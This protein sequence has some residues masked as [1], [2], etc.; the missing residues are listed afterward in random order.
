MLSRAF[1]SLLTCAFCVSGSAQERMSLISVTNSWK[2]NFTGTNLSGQFQRPDYD[3][4]A[5][6]S[7][8]GVLG[9]DASIPYLY[10]ELRTQF[11]PGTGS[12]TTIYFRTH[13]NF[14][15]NTLGAELWSTNYVDDGAVFYLN[16]HE[17]Q[18]VRM[19]S[20]SI[21]YNTL[22]YTISNPEGQGNV[23]NFP[24]TNLIQG[25]NVL[26]VEVHQE[27][28][29]DPD[30]IFGMS[31][32]ALLPEP[33]PV[34]ITNQPPSRTIEES[35]STTFVA[36]VAGTPPYF[37]QW[38]K[39]GVE[40][41]GETNRSLTLNFVSLDAAG[42]YSFTVS[43]EFNSATSSNA[44]LAV[45][46]GPYLFV[47]MTDTWRYNA[48]GTN[49]GVNWRGVG[50]SDFLWP[51][52]GG[53]FYN[54]SGPLPAP[55]G[56]QLPL[57]NSSGQ[58]IITWYFRTRFHWSGPTS[59]VRLRART[60][61]DDGAVFYINGIEAGRLGMPAAPAIIGYNTPAAYRVEGLTDYNTIELASPA[62]VQGENVLAVE[63]HQNSS[64][65]PDVVFG[66]ALST[67]FAVSLPD[68]IFWGPTSAYT[69]AQSFFPE[70]CDLNEGCGTCSTRR[71]L[72]FD[73]ETRNIGQA[74]LVL[75]DP[76]NNP[77]FVQDPCHGHYHFEGFAEYR[78]LDTNG[79]QVAVGNKIGFCLLDYA[80]WDPNASS[81]DYYNC[82]Y[83]GIQ[84][85][86][87]DFY[88]S[89]LPCQW[90]D[91][92]GLPGGTYIL[93][94]E[95]DPQNRIVEAD[96]NNNVARVMVWFPDCAPPANDEF[97]AA[98][99]IPEAISSITFD[100]RCA[101]QECGEPRHDPGQQGSASIWYQWTAPGNGKLLLST[102]G[103]TFDTLVAVYRGPDLTNLTLVARDDDSGWYG[104]SRLMCDTV[105]GTRYSI[106][107][108][109]YYGRGSN[110]LFRLHY[111]PLVPPTFVSAELQATQQLRLTLSGEAADAYAIETYGTNAIWTE[112]LRVTNRTGT[113]QVID[114]AA[115]GPLKC[116]RARLLP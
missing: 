13:F 84:R 114:P 100:S 18:R 14:P 8:P 16:G 28:F 19:P 50:F 94:L 104:T 25:D 48:G 91:I 106:A 108:D 79:V 86:W 21:T 15:S 77:L 115:T 36:E 30:I 68:L 10:P 33:G 2:Y 51:E 49:L 57:T 5:W 102:E 55:K 96:E 99:V 3:D 73:T 41:F 111:R 92:T 4:A 101:T 44:T 95:V 58:G 63:V 98:Q 103:S 80:R 52:A 11:P 110:G 32:L 37:F 75:G 67:N 93:E 56:T 62:L 97:I 107:V 39:D 31:L 88:Y 78:L 65:T 69:E 9:Y 83:Q 61:I 74:D 54:Y 38:F 70:P 1:W 59:G 46:P 64:G 6:P 113:V 90:V 20:G 53:V 112:W 89:T 76:Q 12:R 27:R 47:S 17:V 43:N 87:S 24:I 85:G 81:D 60:L 35:D 109:A 45:T 29:N 82:F 42:D 34:R 116:Y 7:G 66:M 40:I 22:A 23:M 71:V 105:Q 26:A 72:R